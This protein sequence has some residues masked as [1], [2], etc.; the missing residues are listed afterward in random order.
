[1]SVKP[2]KLQLIRLTVEGAAREFGVDRANLAGACKRAD[3]LPGPDGKYSIKQMAAVIFGD[4]ESERI[5][6]KRENADRLAMLNEQLRR[7]LLPRIEIEQHWQNLI[8]I[9][10]QKLL[11]LG[12]RVAPRL[13]FCKGETEMEREINGEIDQALSELARSPGHEEAEVKTI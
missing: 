11:S 9:C 6:E 5:R 10:R 1:M 3:C 4:L 8:L 7:N 2:N 13:V 12:N